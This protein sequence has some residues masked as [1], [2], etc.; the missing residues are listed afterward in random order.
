MTGFGWVRSRIDRPH[1]PPGVRTLSR[2][3]WVGLCASAEAVGMTAAAV[4]AKLSQHVLGDHPSGWDAALALMLVVTGG[5]VEGGALGALQANGLQRLIPRLNRR[6]W[7][8]VTVTVAGLGWAAASV[9]G[10]FSDDGGG[11][12]PALLVVVA[13]A[14]ALGA[15]M[16]AVL[17]AAQSTT[18]RR[19]V[20][21]SGRW[22]LA[23]TIAWPPTMVVIFVG[24][25]TP[26]G[27]WSIVT[28]AALGAITGLA[29]GTV[30]GVVTGLF[31]TDLDGAVHEN[32]A[33]PE[34]PLSPDPQK[35]TPHVTRETS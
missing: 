22:M 14:L 7:L 17:G 24:A 12:E 1:V 34:E 15:A 4:A 11:A 21:H 29:A 35:G 18:L 31:L 27:D 23:N 26:E 32:G 13:G 3:R 30:L 16:G 33:V 2:T 9:P 25:T 10:V 8:L 28:V 6:R 20:A 19:L 5:L